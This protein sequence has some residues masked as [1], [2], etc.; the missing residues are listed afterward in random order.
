[1]ALSSKL[2]RKEGLTALA[3]RLLLELGNQES[4]SCKFERAKLCWVSGEKHRALKMLLCLI[5]EMDGI[6]VL[7]PNEIHPFSPTSAAIYVSLHA[8]V[9]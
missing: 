2:A 1:M 9:E 6:Q 7:S 8:K 5:H 4:G 3:E